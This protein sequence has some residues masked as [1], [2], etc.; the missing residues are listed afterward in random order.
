MRLTT[1]P[2]RDGASQASTAGGPLGDYVQAGAAEQESIVL[3]DNYR[4]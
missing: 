2:H 3:V 4:R 1:P